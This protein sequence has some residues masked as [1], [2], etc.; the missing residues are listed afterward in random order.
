MAAATAER[1][2]AGA[3]AA[4][5]ELVEQGECQSVTAHAN[6]VPQCN[7]AA[8]HVDLVRVDTELGGRCNA[9]SGKCF[10]ELEQVEIGDGKPAF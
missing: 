5:L 4:T 10:V 6:R 3:A 8:V 2:H 7:R 1:G 9:D